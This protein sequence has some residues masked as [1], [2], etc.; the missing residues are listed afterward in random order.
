MVHPGD[1]VI[2]LE[3]CY[4]SYVPDVELAGGK[5]VQVPLTPGTFRPN[6]DKIS[7]AITSKTRAIIVNSLHDPCA[8]VWTEAEMLTLQEILAPTDVLLINDEVYAARTIHSHLIR[9]KFNG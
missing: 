5:V 9:K 4:D 2:V 8:T 3:H 7:A 1:E 6:F